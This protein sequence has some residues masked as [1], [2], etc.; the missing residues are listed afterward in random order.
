MKNFVVQLSVSPDVY[1]KW[2]ETLKSK[3]LRVFG[4]GAVMNELNTKLFTEL[5][6]DIM[7]GRAHQRYM[8][9][10]RSI[11][12]DESRKFVKKER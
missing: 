7:E 8:D 11:T 10:Y 1:D 3:D 5:I 12:D 9:I 6:S 4:T 2:K